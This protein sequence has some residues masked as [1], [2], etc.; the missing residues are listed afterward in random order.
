MKDMRKMKQSIQ[1]AL[2]GMLLVFS[3][4]LAAQSTPA[5]PGQGQPKLTP[6][7]R[8]QKHTDRMKASLGLDEKQYKQVLEINQEQAKKLEAQRLEAQK[9]RERR[10]AAMR[11]MEAS[12]EKR[13]KEVLTEDQYVKYLV[14]KEQMKGR[15][16]ARMNENRPPHQGPG[17]QKGRQ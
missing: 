14:Q 3:T 15:A 7:E 9:E 17:P 10:Q 2:L 12:H 16:K 8:A 1:V 5:G 11:E 6:A 4:E 13:M